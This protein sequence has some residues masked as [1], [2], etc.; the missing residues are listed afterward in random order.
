METDKVE[1]PR[2]RRI[3]GTA[4]SVEGLRSQDLGPSPFGLFFQLLCALLISTLL[5]AHCGGLA[6]ALP[7]G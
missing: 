1:R 5:R 3:P 2:L 6:Q 4:S 7:D